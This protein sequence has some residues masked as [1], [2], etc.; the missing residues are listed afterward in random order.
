MIFKE[1]TFEEF[2]QYI[3][4]K[5]LNINNPKGLYEGY[6]DAGWIDTR[7]NPVVNWKLKLQ[8]LH[9]FTEKEVEKEK[10][11]NINKIQKISLGKCCYLKDC[12]TNVNPNTGLRGLVWYDSLPW[13]CRDHYKKWVLEGRPKY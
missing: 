3:A 8:T 5:K 2:L 4:E 1:P 11:N 13:C 10:Q 7:G 6:A 9:N 12:G